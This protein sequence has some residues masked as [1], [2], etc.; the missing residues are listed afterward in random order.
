MMF[1]AGILPLLSPTG[2]HLPSL[3][4]IFVVYNAIYCFDND[5]RALDCSM[6]SDAWRGE[7]DVFFIEIMHLLR[8]KLLQK[9]SKRNRVTKKPSI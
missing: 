8:Y 3:L 5:G 9:N 7:G 1:F 6:R 4:T 2:R